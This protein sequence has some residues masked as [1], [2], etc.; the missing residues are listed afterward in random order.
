MERETVT[1]VELVSSV[2]ISNIIYNSN[3]LKLAGKLTCW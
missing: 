1:T 2:Y 3:L